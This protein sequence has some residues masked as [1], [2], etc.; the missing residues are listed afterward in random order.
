[1]ADFSGTPTA[2]TAPHTVQFT[3]L[4]S[5]NTVAW[6]WD[7]GDGGT[8]TEQH[9]SYEYTAEGDYTV[10]LTA[11]NDCGSDQHVA[12]DYVH[13]DAPSPVA[14]AMSDI[15][16][17]GTISGTYSDTHASDDV[18]EIITEVS[19]ETHPRKWYSM[20]EH[21]WEFNVLP[22][23]EVIFR[24]EARRPSNA[25][26]DDFAFEYSTNGIDFSPLL[27]VSSATEQVY[28]AP[29]PSQVS[30]T[31]YVR[32]QDT[33]RT[34]R[35]QS[36][37]SIFI[38]WMAIETNSTPLPPVAA[39]TASPTSGYAPLIVQF[40]DASTGAPSSWSWD[41]GDGGSSTLQH[42]SHQYLIP[43]T[44]TVTLTVTNAQGSDSE[45]KTDYIVV[46]EQI[47]HTMHVHDMVV[48][49]KVA[50]PNHSGRCTVWIVDETDQPVEGA[51]VSVTASGPVSGSFSGVTAGDGTVKFET[52]KI[53]N[54]VGEWCFEVTDVTHS[55]HGYD[56]AANSVTVACESGPVRDGEVAAVGRLAFQLVRAEGP[57]LISFT[58]SRA[59]RVRVELFDV[60]GTRMS[61]LADEWRSAGAHRLGLDTSHLAS[62]VYFCRLETGESRITRKLMIVQ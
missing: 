41:F 47:D 13:V 56:P 6:L 8:S 25:D 45:T 2:G 28:A 48:T 61:L 26:G 51:T 32:V 16:M 37:D 43:E 57:S 39:F 52:G 58:L 53:R 50:G 59:S 31:V 1:V 4:S 62:G 29:I 30:G 18:Y 55:I 11:S 17:T 40:T 35:N 27:A 38:D 49:R 22:G 3:D 60:T 54:P 9:P 15:P 12:V 33:D 10:S 46:L 24:L 7:F 23:V 34:Q 44:Y 36:L 42:P 20:L 19:S 5:A 14:L 21:R